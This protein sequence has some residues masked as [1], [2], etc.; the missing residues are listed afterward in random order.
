[1]INSNIEYNN[2]I[3]GDDAN[4][5]K[6]TADDSAGLPPEQI[7]TESFYVIQHY[8]RYS[9]ENHEVWKIMWEKR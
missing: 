6:K 3:D 1:M 9:D 4:R 5:T 7:D 2:I 8:D